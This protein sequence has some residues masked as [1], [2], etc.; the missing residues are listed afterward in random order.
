[1]Q[2]NASFWD[3][4]VFEGID[5]MNVEAVTT[6]FGTVHVAVRGRTAGASCPDCGTVSERVHA[7]Y[8]R[9]LRDLPL[10]GQNVV[11]RLTVRRFICDATSCP[12]RTFAEP[13][14][15]LT[16]PYARFTR[17]LNHALEQVGLALAGRAGAC[18]AAQLGLGAGRM[19][20]LR[21]IMALPDPQFST[22][23]VLGVD[24]F[25]IR[26]GQTYSTVLTCG[27]AHHVVDVLPT[28]ESGP[29][30]A[31]LAT[32]PGVE[33]ICR[34]RAGAYAEGARLGA[35]DALQVADRFHLWQGLGR[36]VE[37]CVAAHCDCL[38]TRHPTRRP[39]THSPPPTGRSTI[40]IPSVDGPSGRRLHTR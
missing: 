38:R 11:I 27:E 39:A 29:L 40:R 9:R 12:R 23:R 14:T 18:L 19:T 6:A 34:D 31:W 10:G 33:I 8:Q 3:S 17:R 4:L 13:F 1:M 28:R 30:A 16:S 36:A 35:P 25:T 26:R 21:R 5:D 7:C 22:P 20:L 32:H 2:G 15:R 37:T 24:D